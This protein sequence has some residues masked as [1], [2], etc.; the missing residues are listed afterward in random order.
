MAERSRRERE[1]ERHRREVLE[2]AEAVFAQKG[3]YRA[4]V[5]EIAERAEFAVGTIYTMFESKKA[6]YY[7]LVQ[8]RAR[9]YTESVRE[10][11]RQLTDPREQIRAVVAAKLKFFEENQQFFR[12]FTSATSGED[13]EAPFA[14]SE[15]A[16]KVYADY[17]R[18]VSDVFREGI[19]Q[20]V[21]VQMN[22]LLLT[23]ALE[24][25]TN[26]TIAHSI[27]T[28]GEKL[29][30]ATPERIERLLFGGILARQDPQS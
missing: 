29:A 14:L 28:G 30:E 17:M 21:F 27:H 20:K 16:R 11:I 2:A 13:R 25:I 7:E 8:M 22:P 5:Q 4:T 12:I 18:M 6:I 19:R 9:E 24:G 1:R 3:F 26:S 15:E 10:T 23:L